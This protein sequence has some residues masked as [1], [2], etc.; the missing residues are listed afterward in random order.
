MLD[1]LINWWLDTG[2]EL[3]AF[4]TKTQEKIKEYSNKQVRKTAIVCGTV[5]LVAG[6]AIGLLL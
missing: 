5:G 4:N 3:T 6:L 1:K 2:E